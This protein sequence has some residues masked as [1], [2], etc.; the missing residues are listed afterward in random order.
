MKA[1]L[2]DRVVAHLGEGPALFP[3]SSLYWVDILQGDVWRRV[4]EEPSELVARYDHEVSKV[5]PW[6]DGYLVCGRE[7]VLFRDGGGRLV[8]ETPL[9]SERSN[10]RCSDATVAPDGTVFLG[11]IDRDLSAGRSSLLRLRRDGGV[12]VVVSGADLSNGITLHPDGGSLLWIDSRSQAIWHWEWSGSS[13]QRYRFAEV[14][15]EAG[16]PDGLCVDDSGRSYVALWGGGGVLVMDP[17]GSPEDRIDVAV[18]HVTSCAFDAEDDL[19]ITT[20]AVALGPSE[21]EQYP[22]AGC[23]WRVPQSEL[24]RRGLESQVATITPAR[25]G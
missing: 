9:H 3:D 22:G 6:R 24:G 16:V 7:S 11:I 10:L 2:A 17:S 20:A 13:T 21:L 15:A 25:E 8:G 12:D 5:L 4:G 23:L 18:P 14:P 1:I 19:L